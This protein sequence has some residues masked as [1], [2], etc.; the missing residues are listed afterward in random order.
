MA[1]LFFAAGVTHFVFP[2]LY[3]QIMPSWLPAHHFLVLFS[4]FIEIVLASLLFITA[5]S[6]IA[7]WG[8]I[9]FLIAVFPANVQMML[10]YQDINHQ[11]LWLVSLRLPLQIVLILWA[12]Q[13]TRKKQNVV[14]KK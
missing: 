6:H 12:Y 9:L 5:T 14:G 8:I 7:A 4:G 10:N 3:L 13:F 11:Y 2:H 1:I